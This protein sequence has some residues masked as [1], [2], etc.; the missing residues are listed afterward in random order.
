MDVDS[1][2]S[3]KIYLKRQCLKEKC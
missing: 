3:C 2:C 1:I